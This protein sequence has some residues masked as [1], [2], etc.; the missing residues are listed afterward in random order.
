MTRD[1]D[2][3]VDNSAQRFILSG[4]KGLKAK[5]LRMAATV[6]NENNRRLRRVALRGA[7]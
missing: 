7:A 3:I 2:A 6:Q 4:E 5:G 1:C